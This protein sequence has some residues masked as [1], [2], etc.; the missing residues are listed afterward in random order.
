MNFIMKNITKENHNTYG[1]QVYAYD[2][3]T[4][5]PRNAN[6]AS[7]ASRIAQD[8]KFDKQ[9]IKNIDNVERRIAHA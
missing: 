5:Y 1:G 4:D 3:C 6:S 7:W 8:L 2:F 9:C